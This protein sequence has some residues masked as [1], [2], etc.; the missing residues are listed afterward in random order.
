MTTLG[1]VLRNGD[2][3]LSLRWELLAEELRVR[4]KAPYR[5][6]CK[7]RPGGGRRSL[8][9]R[10]GHGW[11]HGQAGGWKAVSGTFFTERDVDNA[12]FEKAVACI[13]TYV[14]DD[15]Y[16][17]LRI[18]LPTNSQQTLVV[19]NLAVWR[20]KV[21]AEWSEVLEAIAYFSGPG[22]TLNFRYDHR[23]ERVVLEV[24]ARTERNPMRSLTNSPRRF[25]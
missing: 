6:R 23:R 13:S 9:R 15:F 19:Q 12:W 14:R 3:R 8:Q 24:R 11:Q 1:V 21:L 25:N 20:E 7:R 4:V 16:R 10:Y 2:R 5:S 17:D 22:L 18:H